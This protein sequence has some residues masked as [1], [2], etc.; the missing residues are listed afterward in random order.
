MLKD[1]LPGREWRDIQGYEGFYSASNDGYI[2]SHHTNR[3]MATPLV[4]GYRVV[5]LSKNGTVKKMRVGRLIATAFISNP[6]N[7]P[8]VNHLNEIKTDDRVENLEWATHAENTNWGTRTARAVA[9]TDYKAIAAS[10]DHVAAQAK[11]DHKA[12]CTTKKAILQFSIDGEML[13]RFESAKEAAR[14]LGISDTGITACARRERGRQSMYGYRWIYE[15]DLKSTNLQ[16]LKG[17]YRWAPCN[18]PIQSNN[19]S[20]YVGVTFHK[21]RGKWNAQVKYKQRYINL[22]YYTS[23]IEAAQARNEGM[24]WM[25]GEYGRY[26]DVPDAPPHIKEYVKNKCSRFLGE[27]AVYYSGEIVFDEPC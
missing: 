4:N 13:N 9:N 21:P 14:Q 18:K 3:I 24:R 1:N 19:T 27:T 25:F 7:K 20:G 11:V 22:G 17:I 8:T 5:N 6:E 16:G 10:Y 12:C 23:I 15:A 26:N 2:Y